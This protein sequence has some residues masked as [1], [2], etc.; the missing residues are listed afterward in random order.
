MATQCPELNRI[1][2]RRYYAHLRADAEKYASR[3]AKRR[4]TARRR[5]A[6]TRATDSARV[7]LG[8]LH[9]SPRTQGEISA[10]IED[11]VQ[12]FHEANPGGLGE[13]LLSDATGTR[14][15]PARRHADV[16]AATLPDSL[17]QQFEERAAIREFDGSLTRAD[18]EDAAFWELLDAWWE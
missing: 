9:A 12:V 18:A 10:S 1:Y 4:E 3:L 6:A 13:K 5:R 2:C 17:R 8:G 14:P 16:E 15:P 7:P 11:R